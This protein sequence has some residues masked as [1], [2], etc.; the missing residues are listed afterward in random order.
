MYLKKLRRDLP[1]KVRPPSGQSEFAPYIDAIGWA[2]PQLPLGFGK[3]VCAAREK[4]P[5]SNSRRL[6]R[7]MAQFQGRSGSFCKHWNLL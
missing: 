3:P 1:T 7:L 6:S 4:S 2:T 5:R